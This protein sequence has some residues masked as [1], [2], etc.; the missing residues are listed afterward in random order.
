MRSLPYLIKRSIRSATQNQRALPDFLI[1]GAQK[2]A[3]TSLYAYLAQ[4][5][6]ILRSRPKEIFFFD[7]GDNPQVNTYLKGEAWYRSHFPL[8]KKLANGSVT[9]EASTTYLFNPLVPERIHLML[10]QVK[11]I[12]LLRDPTERAISH[13]FHEKRKGKETLP[14][15]E[16][17][18]A[19]EGRLAGIKGNYKSEEF[20]CHAYKT[21]G[22]YCEQIQRFLNVFPKEQM[23]I[24]NNDDFASNPDKTLQEI[25]EFTGVDPQVKI[26]CLTR[27]NVGSGQTK[28][29]P[30]ITQNLREFFRPHNEA[31]YDLIG[32]N[33]GWD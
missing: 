30:E 29:D 33:F 31:L 24:L 32:K 2:A 6:Q 10:P 27:Q 12:A 9:F 26:P 15:K 11:L 21:R 17:L 20:M 14:L 23:L 16:A 3:T 13:Y 25:F 5:P 8:Q 18:A 19:E 4:H 28:I 1:I 22:L 7:G